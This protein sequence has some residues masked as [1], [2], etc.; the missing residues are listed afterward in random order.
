MYSMA[1]WITHGSKR[2]IWTL[3]GSEIPKG[4]LLFNENIIN[5]T[6]CTVHYLKNGLVAIVHHVMRER[7]GF[8]GL[9]DVRGH[10]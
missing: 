10:R 3:A 5:D 8:E 4:F 1:A 2:D 9:E 6:N 7:C